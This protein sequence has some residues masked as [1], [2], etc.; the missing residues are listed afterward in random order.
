MLLGFVGYPGSNCWI[1]DWD[2]RSGVMTAFEKAWNWWHLQMEFRSIGH[3]EGWNMH[4][5][6]KNENSRFLPFTSL[7]SIMCSAY[8]GR[9]RIYKFTR[10]AAMQEVSRTVLPKKRTPFLLQSNPLSGP[11]T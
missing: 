11:S 3:N 2:L 7:P 8:C 5:Y 9:N 4:A 1:H 10:R 6:L